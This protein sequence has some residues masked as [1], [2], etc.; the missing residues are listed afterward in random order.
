MDATEKGKS[1]IMTIVIIVGFIVLLLIPAGITYVIMD[2][3]RPSNTSQITKKEPTPAYKPVE[4]KSTANMEQ[5]KVNH[6]N[7]QKFINDIDSTISEYNRL[8]K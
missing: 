2:R 8:S 1:T 4:A 6:E 7:L 3:Y 5:K